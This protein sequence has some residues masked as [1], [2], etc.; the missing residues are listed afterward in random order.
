MKNVLTFKNHV[1]S[2]PTTAFIYRRGVRY[3]I[4]SNIKP[5][6]VISTYKQQY[7]YLAGFCKKK[8]PDTYRNR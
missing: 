1:E 8:E 2:G 4:Y 5:T 3:C 7:F 6:A